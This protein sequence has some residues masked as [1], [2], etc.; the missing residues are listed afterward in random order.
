MGLSSMHTSQRALQ[1]LEHPLYQVPGLLLPAGLF[2]VGCRSCQEGSHLYQRILQGQSCAQM[3][4]R[5]QRPGAGAQQVPPAC[6][7]WTG[8]DP[9]SAHAIAALSHAILLAACCSQDQHLHLAI[10]NITCIINLPIHTNDDC[11]RNKVVGTLAKFVWA[12]TTPAQACCQIKQQQMILQMLPDALFC[13]HI[14]AWDAKYI[15]TPPARY[16]Q[17]SGQLQVVMRL[18]A[19]HDHPILTKADGQHQTSALGILKFRP[20]LASA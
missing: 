4:R 2:G 19:L 12:L 20:T 8:G 11:Q 10:A 16:E 17:V 6:A 18:P 3:A 15:T 9:S 1:A 13:K 14:N 7:A 5:P